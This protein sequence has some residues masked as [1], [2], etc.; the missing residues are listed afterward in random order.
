MEVGPRGQD[1]HCD[2]LINVKHV[3]GGQSLKDHDPAA[4]S[5]E[6]PALVEVFQEFCRKALSSEV[7]IRGHRDE[8]TIQL[9]PVEGIY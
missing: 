9:F 5:H 8:E 2:V 6:L 4:A 3:F 7:R 1:R